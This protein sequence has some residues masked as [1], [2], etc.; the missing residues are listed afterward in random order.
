MASATAVWHQV[1]EEV[2]EIHS[3]LERRTQLDKQARPRHHCRCITHVSQLVEVSTS[4]S[5]PS[6]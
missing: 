4:T 6:E 3:K 2:M 5:R 1:K